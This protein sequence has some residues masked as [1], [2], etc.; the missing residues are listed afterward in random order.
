MKKNLLICLLI[1]GLLQTINAQDKSG[2]LIIDTKYNVSIPADKFVKEI[3]VSRGL[4]KKT[5]KGLL[6]QCVDSARYYNGNCF[7]V[8][9]FDEND[10]VTI[11][12][13]KY[14]QDYIRG[15]I[16]TLN[17]S[18][19]QKV[20]ADIE[21]Y[22]TAKSDSLKRNNTKVFQDSSKVIY[23]ANFIFQ[24]G[25]ES[26]LTILPKVNL[27]RVHNL[28]F[29]NPYYGVELGIHPFMV[30]GAFTF[31]GVC[32]VEKGIF[33]LEASITHFRT[34]K[35]RDGDNGYKGPF[36]RNL[37]NLKLGIQ[38][39]EV[40]LKIGTSFLINENIPQRQER[41]DLLDMGKINGRIYGIEL[42]FK[43]K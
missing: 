34:T 14:P 15:N 22:K 18:E 23:K 11:R 40:R 20:N 37:L 43:I 38:I 17:E 41:I 8:T 21:K 13:G 27:L 6:K 39:S 4:L 2:I 7:Q 10:F 5:K 35:I 32:G 19:I 29:I 36:S 28:S 26:I 1:F 12:K 31:S 3:H 9:F 25:G 16:Y 24:Y 30:A 33:N 42:Q